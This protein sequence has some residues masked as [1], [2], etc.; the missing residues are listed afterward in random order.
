VGPGAIGRSSGLPSAAVLANA[1]NL[2]GVTG[3]RVVVS[4]PDFL[5]QLVHIA[6]KKFHRTPAFGT[7]H[8]V[9]A[10]PVV[11]MLVARDAIVEGDFASQS[12]L[13]EQFKCAVDGGVADAGVLLLDEAVQFVGGEVVA[14]FKERAQD[15]IAL[16]RLLQADALE[17]LVED[18]L[19]LA[20]HLARDRGLIVYPILGDSL[21]QH[22]GSG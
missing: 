22:E 7:D 19:G 2:E 1:V 3:R 15:G 4:A 14:G 6:G 8:M 10:A 17:V 16:R 11:L 20:H 13:G 9:M 21:L 5:L 12:A 18:F